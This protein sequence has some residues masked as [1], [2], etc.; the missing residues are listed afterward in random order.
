MLDLLG[1]QTPVD[2][3][4]WYSPPRHFGP[5]RSAATAAPAAIVKCPTY[6]AIFGGGCSRWC[7]AADVCRTRGPWPT[8]YGRVFESVAFFYEYVCGR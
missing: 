2:L 6:A 3:G 1:R 4:N 5:S 7:P 8:P